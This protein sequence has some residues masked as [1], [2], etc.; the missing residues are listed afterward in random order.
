MLRRL[1]HVPKKTGKSATGTSVLP[2]K[3]AYC[4]LNIIYNRSSQR[5]IPSNFNWWIEKKINSPAHNIS[6]NISFRFHPFPAQL[7]PYHH[8][9]KCENSYPIS[10]LI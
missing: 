8:G 7:I 3:Y 10:G 5:S 4:S 9:C 6:Y 1:T 2:D